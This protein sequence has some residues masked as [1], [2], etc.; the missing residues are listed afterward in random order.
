MVGARYWWA[1][2]GAVS[3]RHSSP[4]GSRGQ[5]RIQRVTR[6]TCHVATDPAV[7]RGPRQRYAIGRNKGVHLNSCLA[8]HLDSFIL[9]KFA[10]KSMSSTTGQK[11]K[12][13]FIIC[14]PPQWA[15]RGGAGNLVRAS[16][17]FHDKLGGDCTVYSNIYVLYCTVRALVKTGRPRDHNDEG[18]LFM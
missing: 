12:L 14:S 6:V 11:T 3:P 16:A 10:H 9:D 5:H 15:V 2:S 8:R 7:T 4:A 1:V 17:N 13:I 18:W